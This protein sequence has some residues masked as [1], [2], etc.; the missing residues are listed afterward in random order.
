MYS[1]ALR[2]AH[3]AGLATGWRAPGGPQ[4]PAGCEM[5]GGRDC[6]AVPGRPE[7]LQCA[8]GISRGAKSIRYHPENTF[9][10]GARCH[11][12][13]SS[14]PVYGRADADIGRR[15]LDWCERVVGDRWTFVLA[16]Q[17][18]GHGA[19]HRL[20]VLEAAAKI[21]ALQDPLCRTWATQAAA[22]VRNLAAVIPWP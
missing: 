11:F 19:D 5:C 3:A 20:V 4:F 13:N 18:G 21:R 12:L 9:A 14:R 1:I 7:L 22:S 6:G 2:A 17:R 15:W 16:A 10:L 8:H